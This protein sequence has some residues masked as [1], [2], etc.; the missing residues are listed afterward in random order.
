VDLGVDACED[1][2]LHGQQPGLKVSV[3]ARGL[4]LLWVLFRRRVV[5]SAGGAAKKLFVGAALILPLAALEAAEDPKLRGDGGGR[6]LNPVVARWR[7]AELK[8][9]AALFR[10]RPPGG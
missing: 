5:R 2:R 4:L 9:L 10:R 7:L 6:R 3:A 1:F 8:V